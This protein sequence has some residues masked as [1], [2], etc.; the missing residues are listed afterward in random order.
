[1]ADHCP[2][3]G[4]ALADRAPAEKLSLTRRQGELLEMIGDHIRRHGVAP[5]YD[6]MA[7]AVGLKS[8]SGIVRLVQGLVERGHLHH[9]PRGIRALAVIGGPS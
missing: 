6:E 8:K 7:A 9:R 1:M 4:H 5:S 2:H 3:C